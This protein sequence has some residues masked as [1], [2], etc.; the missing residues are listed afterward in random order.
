MGIITSDRSQNIQNEHHSAC[1]STFFIIYPQTVWSTEHT[2]AE[3]QTLT[4][5]PHCS[6]KGFNFLV[7]TKR[8]SNMSAKLFY[9]FFP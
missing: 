8:N 7:E 6:D 2:D 3:L 5:Q 1:W 4:T 9:L